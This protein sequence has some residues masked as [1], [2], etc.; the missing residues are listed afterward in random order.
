MLIFKQ[1][2]PVYG[3]VPAILW[4]LDQAE[5]IWPTDCVVTSTMY[6]DKHSWASLHGSGNAVD[7]RTKNLTKSQRIGLV[8]LLGSIL[9]D[10]Y[11]VIYESKD[12]GHAH[13]EYQP[14]GKQAYPDGKRF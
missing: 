2:V 9:G 4:A 14:K 7:L 11:D 8:G 10:S 12:T 1:G 6:G 3:L 13:V 5:N